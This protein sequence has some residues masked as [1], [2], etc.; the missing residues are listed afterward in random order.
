MKRLKVLFLALIVVASTILGGGFA[1]GNFSDDFIK[2]VDFNVPYGVLVAA[3]KHDVNSHKQGKDISMIKLLAYLASCNGNK[4][5]VANDTY[6]MNKLVDRL[7]SGESE[8]QVFSN[9]GKYFDYY[10][11][12]YKAVLGGLLGNYITE[13]NDMIEQ[14][15]GLISYHPIAKGFYYNCY[16]DF[17][18][19]RNYGFK[20]KHLGHDI[21]GNTG[22][23]IIAVES[24]TITEFGW[25]KYG[26]WRIGIRSDDGYRFYYYAH[27]RKNRPYAEGL[28]KG[29]KVKAGQVI[30]YLGATGYSDKENRNM[31]VNPH[32]HFGLQLIFDESQ[33]KGNNEIWINMYNICKLLEHNRA[34]TVRNTETKEY[35]SVELRQAV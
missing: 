8:E 19:S 23:P 6:R 26:G 9:S 16:D 22:T 24:G 28:K 11:E 12:A 15:Y 33:V 17:G 29:D 7:N 1:Y 18:N 14:D 21:F 20:R 35:Y 10:L 13:K 25:N 5:S 3:Y 32:L 31:D 30:G 27:M 2:W 34:K 4:W